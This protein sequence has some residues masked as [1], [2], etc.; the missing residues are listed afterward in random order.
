MSGVLDVELTREVVFRNAGCEGCITIGL[1][2]VVVV[3]DG[4]LEETVDSLVEVTVVGLD[5]D[6]DATDVG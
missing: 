4:G 1:V 2:I 3:A 6:D 5:A